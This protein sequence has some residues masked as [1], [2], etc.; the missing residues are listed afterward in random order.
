[1]NMKE[2]DSNL[3]VKKADTSDDAFKGYTLEE[4]K[5]QRAMMALRKEFAKAKILQ[6]LEAMKPSKKTGS[7]GSVLG[8]RFALLRS[9]GGKVFSNFNVLDYVMIGMSLFGTAK[10]AYSLFKRSK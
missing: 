5:Y 9:L 4:L 2:T 1:M 6:S 8:S 7:A 3:P 10:K